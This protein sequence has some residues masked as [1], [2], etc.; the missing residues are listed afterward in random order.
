MI[1]IFVIFQGEIDFQR[2]LSIVDPNASG[3]V[4]F[5]CFL[6][7]MTRESTDVDTAEQVIDSFRILAADKVQNQFF[8]KYVQWLLV[9]PKICLRNDSIFS[10]VPIAFLLIHVQRT[11]SCTLFLC[12]LFYFVDVHF[13]WGIETR[14]AARP[15]RIL[16]SE[17]ATIYWSRRCTRCL[18]L[19]V[20]LYSLVW[21]IGPLRKKPFEV[22]KRHLVSHKQTIPNCDLTEKKRK[23]YSA[24]QFQRVK[25]IQ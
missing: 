3:Y 19:H 12:T 22:D 4:Q 13:A 11:R 1:I 24:I 2:I 5:D 25:T 10:T 14:I 7:F 8:T 21:W 23:K 18:R 17:N 20:I 16:H 6:D 15:S 9:L